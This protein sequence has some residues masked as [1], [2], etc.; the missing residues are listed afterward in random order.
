MDLEFIP[1]IYTPGHFGTWVSWLIN[2][3]TRFPR[4]M[5]KPQRRNLPIQVDIGCSL[6]DFYYYKNLSDWDRYYNDVIH[7]TIAVNKNISKFSFKFLPVSNFIS[8]ENIFEIDELNKIFAYIGVKKTVITLVDTTLLTEIKERWQYLEGH[9][10]LDVAE[11]NYQWQ[12]SNITNYDKIQAD[13]LLIDVGE[14]LLGNE[15]EYKKLADFIGEPPL[16][17]FNE[18]SKSYYNFSFAFKKLKS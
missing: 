17:T 8:D 16:A 3:H 11:Y 18:I 4:Y 2:Q 6:G 9:S 14:L 13:C 5:C 10:T 7:K 12:R 1:V 15:D